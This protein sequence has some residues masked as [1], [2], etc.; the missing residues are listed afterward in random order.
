MSGPNCSSVTH[1]F[2]AEYDLCDHMMIYDSACYVK[3][4][5]YIYIY[6]YIYKHMCI[7]EEC[8]SIYIY[9]LK[10]SSQIPHKGMRARRLRFVFEYFIASARQNDSL[11]CYI[12]FNILYLSALNIVSNGTT[13]SQHCLK[14]WLG[15]K[16]PS[17]HY[18]YQ[19]QRDSWREIRFCSACINQ[20][21]NHSSIQA[22]CLCLHGASVL[23]VL[24]IF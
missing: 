7:C 9:I 15:A 22:H 18:L 14:Q 19:C 8:L 20:Y 1:R 10:H 3:I 11:P 24:S 5:L 13:V 16:H 6:V 23:L 21:Q 4:E 12:W 2:F 17:S